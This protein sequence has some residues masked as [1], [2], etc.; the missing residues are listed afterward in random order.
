MRKLNLFLITVFALLMSI[1]A[2][3]FTVV[4][5]PLT[6]LTGY[7]SM[8]EWDTDGDFEEWTYNAHIIDAQVSGGDFIG[9][10]D[11]NDASM[12][13]NI[14]ALT[15]PD[16]R[17]GLATAIDTVFEIRMQFAT[18]TQNG[19]VDFWATI[20][21]AV[22]GTWPPM[23]FAY[24]A[25][26]IPDVPTDGQ[27]HVFRL[28]LE[29]GDDYIGN[30]DALRLDPL[31]DGP[32]GETFRIDYLR[33]AK[34]T[35]QIQII[36]VD[37]APL[38]NYTSLAEWNTDGDFEDWIFTHIVNSNVSGGI[39]SGEPVN[40]DPFFSKT[41]VP[42]V[43]LD[44]NKII[45][46]RIKHDST[47]SSGIQIYFNVPAPETVVAIPADM[48]PT[49]GN[50][51]I[52]QYNMS[53]HS[54]WTGL[55]SGFRL[56]PYI[57]AEAVGKQFEVDYIRVG[58]T[59]TPTVNPSAS[60]GT[61]PDKV[62]VSWNEVDNVN[63][64]Q[65]WRS[66]TD[67]SGTAITNSPELTTN[68]F[69]DFATAND[70]YYYYW[71]KVFMTNDWGAF[72]SSALGFKMAST[73]P[74]TPVNISP[75]GLNVVTSPVQLVATPYHDAG[76][77]PFLVSQWQLSS[78]DDFSPI[79][80]DSGETIPDNHLTPPANASSSI[81][82]FWR[83]RYKKEF[84]TW[85]EWSAG[86]SFILVQQQPQGTIFFDTFNVTG[87][88][89]VNLGYDNA[90]RQFGDTA[91]LPYTISGTAT[92]GTASANPGDLLMGL[93][94]GVSPNHSFT[95]SG[96]IKIE[97]DVVPH[98]LDKTNDW[99]ALTF[100]K[101]SQEN[102]LNPVSISGATLGFFGNGDFMA[103]EGET[104][105]G[106]GT[107]VPT[108][109]KLHIVLTASTEGFDYDSV[110]YSVFANGN[111]MITVTNP[112]LGYVYND[113]GGFDNNY[114]ALY[115]DN[116]ISANTS[117]FDNLKISKVDNIVTVTNWVG[118]SDMLPMNPAETTHAVN[119]N[120]DS[121]TI[122][123]V[124]F[125][126]TG[127]STNPG[128]HAN[129]SAILQSNGWE[130]MSAN[131]TT[132]F[133]NTENVTNI[134]TDIGTKTLM[135]YFAFFN[136]PGGA[137]ALR[138]SDLTPYS[139]N[140]IS[141]YSYG[142]EN[143]NRACYFSSTS[144]GTITNV[145]QDMYGIGSGIIVRYSYVA[146]GNGECTILISTT[147]LGGWHLSGF[148]SEEIAAVPSEISVPDKLDF[149]DAVVGIPTT[150][151][152]EVMNI[153]S[154]IVSGSISGISSP[155][156]LADSYYATSATSD[157]ITVTF[158]PSAEDV[159]SE[160]VTLSGSGG[161]AQVVLTGTG[162]PEPS[163]FIIYNLLFVIYYFKIKN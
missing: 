107:G 3:A 35:N 97:F 90:G 108:D 114:I 157:T 51:H 126:G 124:D 98:A 99:I 58:S 83:V 63:K 25:A 87:E 21:G 41:A 110:K 79:I 162:V 141:I 53:A 92:V 134:V 71:V 60:Q 29:A 135:E 2:M 23:Q 52:Y 158:N 40:N 140:V 139:S 149:G 24:T 136:A 69:D 38:F 145:N 93:S 102:A 144:G 37:P 125:I 64:Y 138:L 54:E 85:S 91:P 22:P 128:F 150:L 113:E 103:L 82:N 16:P 30:L 105:V 14:D 147:G 4:L 28:T 67:D 76:G 122:N 45:E 32:F 9:K 75:V 104:L 17:K 163:I 143:A 34:V 101:S 39:L 120:G 154:G 42:A 31:A 65:V 56:D 142:W 148:Y 44:L 68:I 66:E 156:S 131:G 73:R 50:F 160:F 130:L 129:G 77:Y 1:N 36:K 81:T 49:D 12:N 80:W 127:I 161:G 119:I 121:V 133:H 62:I 152:L 7:T 123:G 96:N 48:I 8:A 57:V 118:D 20:N 78:E 146:D 111:P 26:G 137:A 70:T 155:F 115:S 59:E 94:S 106:L 18:N 55:L 112:N 19:R 159:Y 116:L 11:G 95:E 89:S 27:F 13:L 109:E 5:D 46:F 86:T 6:P 88:G 84:N 153:G 132:I 117:L 33:V 151:S 61:Y 43:D 10:D 74:D 47:V 100:G 72:G 15:S